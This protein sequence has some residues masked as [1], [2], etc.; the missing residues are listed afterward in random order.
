MV[1]KHQSERIDGFGAS[2]GKMDGFRAS[3]ERIDSYWISAE[4]AQL[5]GVVTGYQLKG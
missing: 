2:V 1:S 3:P 4:R 5:R